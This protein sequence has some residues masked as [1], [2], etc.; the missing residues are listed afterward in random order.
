MNWLKQN[1]GKI[2]LVIVVLVL[3]FKDSPFWIVVGILGA[4]IYLIIKK[5]ISE[6]LRLALAIIIWM[7]FI[8]TTGLSIYVNYYLPHG[9]S[10]PTGNVVC[11]SDYGGPCGD[12]YKEDLQGLNI[13]DWAK[14]FRG[15]EST[16]LWMGLLIAGIA[17]SSD[18]KKR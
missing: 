17:I 13:P 14:F 11:Q 4:G 3:A 18:N 10:Y 9:P 15:S 7:I 8:I 12:E 6:K 1:W 5:P 2:I 16:L